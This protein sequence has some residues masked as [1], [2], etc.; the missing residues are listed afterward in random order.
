MLRVSRDSLFRV[1]EPETESLSGP[2]LLA[3]GRRPT[4]RAARPRRA[5]RRLHAA[6]A[7][8]GHCALGPGR[9]RGP[10]PRA[11]AAALAFT[12]HIDTIKYTRINRLF[13]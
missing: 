6:L 5:A 1:E 10:A 8:R 12:T 4:R 11:R 9:C 13:I 3:S 2:L 7:P